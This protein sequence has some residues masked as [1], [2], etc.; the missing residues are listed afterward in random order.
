MKFDEV[1]KY[2][3]VVYLI[4]LFIGLLVYLFSDFTLLQK[5]GGVLIYVLA[6]FTAYFIGMGI[7]KIF[8]RIR[9]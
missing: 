3:G 5:L 4:I 1:L 7:Y 9:R 8:E 6:F 2:L